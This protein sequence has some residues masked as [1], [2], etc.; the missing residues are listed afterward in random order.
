MKLIE[1]NKEF[2]KFDLSNFFVF[3]YKE[4]VKNEAFKALEARTKIVNKKSKKSVE[5]NIYIDSLN[6]KNISEDIVKN[7]LKVIEEWYT[8][9]I[10]S[11]SIYSR[12]PS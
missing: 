11:S 4:P 6:N 2:L 9:E 10:E 1:E 5:F 8:T 7:N 12:F 3:V